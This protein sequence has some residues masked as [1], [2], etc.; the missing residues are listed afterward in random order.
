MENFIKTRTCSGKELRNGEV[1]VYE[2]GT[3]NNYCTLAYNGEYVLLYRTLLPAVIPT[4]LLFGWDACMAVLAV[5]D[6]LGEFMTISCNLNLMNQHLQAG[7]IIYIS[8]NANGHWRFIYKNGR[9][10]ILMSCGR[11]TTL[12]PGEVSEGL[13][14]LFPPEELIAMF[15]ID[16][17]HSVDGHA[18]GLQIIESWLGDFPLVYREGERPSFTQKEDLYFYGR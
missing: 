16:N 3:E 5:D 18:G 7:H 9:Y 10:Y 6:T 17:S 8:E 2:W 12:V 15:K 13:I 11:D 4:L 1:G 14:M